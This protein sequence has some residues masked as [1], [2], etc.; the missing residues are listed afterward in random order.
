MKD[1]TEKLRPEQFNLKTIPA[2]LEEVGDLW[3]DFWKNRQRLE[4]LLE[5]RKIEV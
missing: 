3:K 2:R 4:T 1:V 5:Q